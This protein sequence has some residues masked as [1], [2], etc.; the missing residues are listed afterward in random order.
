MAVELGVAYVSVVPSARDFGANLRKQLGDLSAKVA[1]SVDSSAVSNLR[2][3]LS[4]F[5][6]NV[7]VNVDG[8]AANSKLRSSLGDQSALGKQMGE[9]AG[10]SM[11]SSIISSATKALA[12]VAATI[13][14]TKAAREGFDVAINFETTEVAFAGLLGSTEAAQAKLEEL[15]NFAK[16]TPFDFPSMADASKKL[17]A[18]GFDAESIIPTMQTLGDAAAALGVRPRD[19]ELVVR[20]LGQIISKGR[21]QL[22]EL[23]QIAENFPG[24]N[25]IP[26]LAA[27][28]NASVPDFVKALSQPGGALEEFGL[29]GEQAVQTI[30]A[31]FKD[32][33]GA[34]GAM[35]RQ[36]LTLKGALETLKD[37]LRITAIESLKPF[38]PGISKAIRLTIV[39]ALETVGDKVKI[40]ASEMDGVGKP[41][42]GRF[43]KMGDAVGRFG[44]KAGKGLK[45]FRSE[46]D[47]IGKP[48]EGEFAKIG[49]AVG[50]FLNLLKP[51][52]KAFAD[53]FRT[54]NIT[55]ADGIAGTA[56]RL[57]VAFRGAVD[58]VKAFATAFV[59]GKADVD[60]SGFSGLMSTLGDM[61]RGLVDWLQVQIPLAID[62]FNEAWDLAVPKV[63][64]FFQFLVDNKDTLLLVTAGI[65]GFL[66]AM[67][68]MSVVQSTAKSAANLTTAL[69]GLGPGGVVI[70]GLLALA[71][72]LTA[73]Y[74]EIPPFQDA[75]KDVAKTFQD[76]GPSAAIED[77]TS[78]ID[79][80]LSNL[81]ET[82]KPKLADFFTTATAF[83][84]EKIG[85][86]FG[87]EVVPQEQQDWAKAFNVQP[88]APPSL[89]F[90]GTSFVDPPKPKIFK[91]FAEGFADAM[92]TEIIPAI[93][94]SINKHKGDLGKELEKLAEAATDWAK[95]PKNWAGVGLALGS[96]IG[97]IVSKNMLS[98]A[99]LLGAIPEGIF[100]SLDKAITVEKLAPIAAKIVVGILTFPEAV[101]DVIDKWWKAAFDQLNTWL[102]NEAFQRVVINLVTGILTFPEDVSD[103][104]DKWWKAAFDQLNTWL[105]NEK[106]Q[107]VVWSIVVGI[108]TFPEDAFDQI[109]KWW[110]AAFDQLDKW[111]TVENIVGTT[112]KIIK[113]IL[114]LPEGISDVIDKWWTDLF[115]QI[116]KWFDG[117]TGGLWSGLVNSFKSAINSIIG[118]WNGLDFTMTLPGFLGGGSATIGM[119]DIDPIPIGNAKGN[120][121][122]SD[123]TG[124]FRFAET[125]RARPEV[126]SPVSLM[127]ETFRRELA[128]A[129]G[130]GRALVIEGGLN[131]TEAASA[132]SVVDEI[133]ARL[134][135][136]LTTRAER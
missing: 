27:S 87:F 113:G 98:D 2:K 22:E 6:T 33:K 13:G 7:G 28:V 64:D 116:D 18:F 19:T 63:R 82:W 102:T 12:T 108:L 16:V 124:L 4:G 132:A 112:W 24:S 55:T 46:L 35:Q 109:D 84:Q 88:P 67:K 125:S 25:P 69:L 114:T 117:Q 99:L 90:P 17:L 72:A 101:S 85:D 51:L 78:K 20:A 44:K 75:V 37:Q 62:K 73:A 121:F 106:F 89:D 80:F 40:F 31:S 104:I 136:M 133:H 65:G 103:Q 29:T 8:A 39:P 50:R 79:T 21:V 66:V 68:E 58:G 92:I 111:L 34:E 100:D 127:A 119:P 52:P 126:V 107:D 48:V 76:E 96:S 128:N 105:T 49:D 5:S 36:S 135:W 41:V 45:E 110:K 93:G 10:S 129:P 43:A 118:I 115:D 83:I 30:L 53:A 94:D 74:I 71:G 32:I 59:T 1:V 11:S 131:I 77:A 122:T 95:D 130:N 61:A 91:S 42:E 3:Q 81:W 26:A 97:K 57:G 14:L 60:A 23:I 70:A 123:T 56:E 134:G 120:V 54:G 47:G 38:L 9:S 15:Q 86:L